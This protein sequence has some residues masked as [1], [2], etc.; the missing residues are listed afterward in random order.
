M[1]KVRQGGLKRPAGDGR[2]Q[3]DGNDAVGWMQSR[4]RK[5]PSAACGHA[6]GRLKRQILRREGEVQAD[7]SGVNKHAGPT[8]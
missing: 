5:L 2:P 6:Q 3:G 4:A 8:R 7:D 1:A